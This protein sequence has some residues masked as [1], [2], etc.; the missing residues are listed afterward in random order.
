MLMQIPKLHVLLLR[1]LPMCSLTF[2]RIMQI[3]LKLKFF[4]QPKLPLKKN[5][6]S[7]YEGLKLLPTRRAQT[8][9]FPH[10]V[11]SHSHTH[12]HTHM[13]MPAG[14]WWLA[15]CCQQVILG[16]VCRKGWGVNWVSTRCKSLWV[17]ACS[18]FLS[19][20]SLMRYR[21]WV[22]CSCSINGLSCTRCAAL[23][24]VAGI[25]LSVFRVFS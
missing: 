1:F 12:T 11:A 3:D 13:V 24:F 4:T 8:P 16:R 22:K 18:L 21:W 5:R 10:A 19:M 25:S 23:S 9:A 17:E 15:F 7:H 6:C 20:L 2:I 14:R